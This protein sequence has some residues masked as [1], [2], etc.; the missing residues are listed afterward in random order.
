MY[1]KH[2]VQVL[3]FSYTTGISN[4]NVQDRH[5]C[6]ILSMENTVP[7]FALTTK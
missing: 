4:R 1:T 5:L 3:V 2:A 7:A 6:A